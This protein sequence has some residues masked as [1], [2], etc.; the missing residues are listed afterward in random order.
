MA[1]I[2]AEN[3]LGEGDVICLSSHD[4][5]HKLLSADAL[6]ASPRLA[7]SGG[8]SAFLPT[9]DV[10]SHSF[11]IRRAI[12]TATHSGPIQPR[13]LVTLQH[14]ASGQY[15]SENSVVSLQPHAGPG[16]A[17]EIGRVLPSLGA[18][19][20]QVG[21]LVF[22]RGESSLQYLSSSS[23]G[24][25]A[26]RCSERPERWRLLRYAERAAPR[27]TGVVNGLRFGDL[28]T[29]SLPG[30]AAG[31]L[32]ARVEVEEGDVSL[33]DGVVSGTEHAARL[34][35]A[36]MCVCPAGL[37]GGATAVAELEQYNM[38][39]RGGRSSRSSSA[40]A[41][42]A[43]SLLHASAAWQ[44]VYLPPDEPH[45]SAGAAIDSG[46]GTGTGTAD[47]GAGSS[48]SR[49][50][51]MCAPA[52]LSGATRVQLCHVLTGQMM[53]VLRPTQQPHSLPPGGGY[54]AYGAHGGARG[55]SGGLALAPPASS[56]MAARA[57]SSSCKVVG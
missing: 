14:V 51:A 6:S 21:E 57:P 50:G 22:V 44:I 55:Q 5:Q 28:V 16:A 13:E 41:T 48:V 36:V 31:C 7:H 56:A 11:V 40:T 27:M 32:A 2:L 12:R 43:S 38:S 8:S 37:E 53:A 20:L 19:A 49:A 52:L 17:W 15:L 54:G 23:D 45:L 10:D 30:D 47:G 25:E 35:G 1:P 42:S 4:S 26:V 18:A 24:G 39:E 9:E 29:L 33:V 3:S 46:T 34:K